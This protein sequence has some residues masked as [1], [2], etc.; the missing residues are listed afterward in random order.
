METAMKTT[1]LHAWHVGQSANMAAFGGYEM[2][3]WYP[4]GAKSEHL[5]VITGAGLFDTSHMAV[6]T[7]RGPR[8]RDLLQACFSKD[9]ERCLGP[10]KGPLVPGRCV[11]GVFL[12]ESGGVLDD[13]IVYQCTGIDY[14]LVVNASMGGPIASH[15]REQN[16]FGGEAEIV[17]RT[18][19]VGKMDI[20]GPKATAILSRVL[21]NPEQVF[22]KMVYF[23]FK[24]SFAPEELPGSTTLLLDGTPLMVSRTG[25][26][27]EFGFELFIG[28]EHVERLW[29]LLLEAGSADGL[30]A[31]GLAARDSLRAGAGLPLSH[32]DIGPWLFAENPWLFV[33]P[34][35]ES[36]RGFTKACLGI[37]AVLAEQNPPATQ[38]FAG[39]DPRKITLSDNAR[40]TSLEG[41]TIGT[42]LTCTT[43]MAI[44]RVDGRIISLA[45]PVELGRPELFTPRGLCCGF[46]R[47]NTKLPIGSEVMLTDGKRKLKVEIRDDIRPDRTARKPMQ[48]MLNRD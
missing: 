27:G 43:D 47:L 33:L 9:L 35:D 37:R 18:D 11:Y 45:T 20:Q 39:Y 38:A 48:T 3:L 23:S 26:T 32:Q 22:E 1:P 44:D 30:I 2:P 12:D 29:T 17:D 46:V 28:P 41:G 15:L 42:I 14:M 8:V 16:R 5:A 21:K 4:A 6:L 24:G 40:V 10:K 36:G 34:W 19:R 7:L 31:C 13:A 25:Y